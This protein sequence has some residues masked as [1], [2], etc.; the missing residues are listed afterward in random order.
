MLSP[1]G[2]CQTFDEKANGYVRGEG[3]GV[4][5]LKRLTDA[6]DRGDRIY[7]TIIGKAINQDGR[8]A[9]LTAPNK[10]MQVE[11]LKKSVTDAGLSTSE[12]RYIETHGT[13]TF[14]GDYIEVSAIGEAINQDLRRKHPLL[15]GAVKTNIGHLESAAG[16]ASLIKTALCLFHGELV[17]TRSIDK[18]NETFEYWDSIKYKKCPKDCTPLQLWTFVKA[19]RRISNIK[20][21]D[22]YDVRLSL[23]NSMQKMCHQFDMYWGGSWGNNSI[24]DTNLL[25]F[26]N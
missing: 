7:A 15:L 23:T 17:P 21:W 1:D 12:I 26:Y 10:N 24:I 11:L 16:V 2:L 3:V 13:G 18:I 19:A 5:V 4:L 25:I 20:V 9:S 14:L 8:S 6:E 22:K